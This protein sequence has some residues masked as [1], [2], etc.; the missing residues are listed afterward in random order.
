M[1]S[2]RI[3]NC[4]RQRC[5]F[6]N[7]KPAL[8]AEKNEM[9]LSV[10]RNLSKSISNCFQSKVFGVGIIERPLEHKKIRPFYNSQL[11]FVRFRGS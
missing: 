11:F 4:E 10:F 8:F 3:I 1:L 5:N 6:V 9:F 7:A 2:W